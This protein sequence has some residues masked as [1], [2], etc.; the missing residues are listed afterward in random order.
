[1]AT[2]AG[3][4]MYRLTDFIGQFAI[5]F[6]LCV[7][8]A[9][10][11]CLTLISW[12][13]AS[14]QADIHTVISRIRAFDPADFYGLAEVAPKW[15]P[16]IEEHFA[17]SRAQFDLIVSDAGRNDRL[18]IVY[19]SDHYELITHFT[20][21][22]VN[23]GQRVRPALIGHF[24]EKSTSIEFHFMVNHLYRASKESRV[25]QSTLLNKW[26]KSSAL[27]TIA[28]GDYNYDWDVSFGKEKH[29]LGYDQL[30]FDDALR[31]V[32]PAELIKT[33]CGK[34]NTVVD[35]VFVSTHFYLRGQRSEVGIPDT[36]YC[37]LPR[38][39]ESDHRPVFAEIRFSAT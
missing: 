35:F 37:E 26:V 33:H 36:A 23:I 2:I 38:A 22:E 5:I 7:V 11:H 21:D 29:D 16:T 13:I 14:D 19:N 12:N 18:A 8:S 17:S 31:W 34:Y 30:T 39:G 6:A 25:V 27:P 9:R 4:A 24:R 15:I 32:V 28:V 10:S 1:M 3:T 20:I